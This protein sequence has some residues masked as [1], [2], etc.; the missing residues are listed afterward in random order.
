M[1]TKKNKPTNISFEE[2]QQQWSRAGS[3]FDFALLFAKNDI[4]KW[5]T[6]HFKQNFDEGGFDGGPWAQRNHNYPHPT[7]N[8]SGELKNSI[9]FQLEPGVGVVIYTDESK[10]STQRG[11]RSSNAYAVFHNDPTG[12]W[13]INQFSDAPAIQR[14]FIGPTPALHEHIRTSIIN[15]LKSAIQ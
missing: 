7:L 4:G 1:A 14:Q 12:S 5:A 10:F 2:M 11:K 6:D 13:R 3:I 9:S 8:K 15:A